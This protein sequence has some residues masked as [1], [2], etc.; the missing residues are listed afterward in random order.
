[1]K[2]Y[3][4]LTLA[5][6][7]TTMV[8]LVVFIA[9]L[10]AF[11]S[12]TEA[13]QAVMI[14]TDQAAVSQDR[15]DLQ[16]WQVEVEATAQAANQKLEATVQARELALQ[17]QVDQ[18][19]Q[20]LAELDRNS[21]AQIRQLEAQWVELQAQADQAKA[22]IPAIQEQLGALQQAMQNDEATYQQ[23]LAAMAGA[24]SQLRL[25]LESAYAEL[26]AAYQ[27]LAQRQAIAAAAPGGSGD[28]HDDDDDGEH[29]EREDDDD[30]HEG[31][32][33]HEDEHEDDD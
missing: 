14:P 13:G 31:D 25:Q 15:V 29:H 23:E 10:S 1:M 18:R 21:Q 32:D 11:V 33:E 27:A 24:E 12:P 30:E 20:A 6:G 22:A 16:A 8:G 5:A 26:D 3:L 9:L 2:R 7:L 19:R 28:S 17:A 4:A